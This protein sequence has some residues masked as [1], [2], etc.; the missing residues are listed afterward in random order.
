MSS[1]IHLR[2][3]SAYSLLEGAIKIPDLI[4]KCIHLR[5]P[6]VALT[7]TAN[8]FGAM[9]FSLTAVKSGVQPII[10]CQ[11]NFC[12]DLKEQHFAKIVLLA[13][14]HQGYLNLLELVSQ[15]YL[16]PNQ[17]VL[18]CVTV[19][20]LAG[21]TDGLICLT[22][23]YDGPLNTI[24]EKDEPHAAV[25]IDQ[26]QKLF[27]DHLY[28]ELQRHFDSRVKKYE[29]DIVQRELKHENAHIDLAY[30]KGIPLVA[31]NDAYFLEKEKHEAH[32]ILLAI[33]EGKNEY[34]D[35][36]RQL[37]EEHY[38][39]SSLEMK[40]LFYDLPEAFDNTFV[41]S[42]RCSHI[43]KPVNPI[44]PSFSQFTG[45]EDEEE[46]RIQAKAGLADRLAKISYVENEQEYWDR[47]EEELGI[48][49]AMGFPGYFLIVADFIKWATS[50]NI[51]VGPGRGS[52]AGSVVAWALTITGLDP[53][54]F[55]LL[56]ERF[57]NPERVS[58]PD[59]D[60][61][62]CQER[63]D[64]VIHYVQQKYGKE[65]V[66]QIITFGKMQARIVLRDVGRALGLPYGQIDKIAKLVPNNPASPVSLGEAIE[67]EPRLKEE[68]QGDPHIKRLV[69]IAT[70]LEGLYRHASTHAAGVVIGD[71]DLTQLVALYKD[72][73]SDMPAT[74]FNMKFV[75]LTGLVKFDFLGLKT[76][77]VIQKA[78]DLVRINHDIDINLET[79]PL[80]DTKTFEMLCRGE[81]MGVFQIEG[82]GM[83]ETIKKMKPTRFEEL[84]ALISLYRPGPMENIP[85]F[86]ARKFGEEEIE[87]LHPL[88]GEI[89]SETYGIMIY[90]EQVMQAAQRLAG[91]S[92]GKADLLRR[93]MGKKVKEEMD[94]QRRIFLD[95]ATENKIDQKTANE[96][97]DQMAKFAGYGFNKSH[98]AG[99]ALM[100]YQTAYLKA[101]YPV[102]FFTSLMSYDLINTDKLNVYRQDA[103]SFGL[104]VL[105][106]DINKSNAHFK[107][108][109]YD[110]EW[111]IRYALGALKNVG[112][113]FLV[114]LE[115]IRK[116]KGKFEDIYDFVKKVGKK[117][118]NKK[119][120][121][122]MIAAGA[123]DSICENRAQL[124]AAIELLADFAATMEKEK[125]KG[126]KSLFGDMDDSVKPPVLPK[127]R[128]WGAVERLNKEF[129]SVGYYLFDHPIDGYQQQLAELD[130][131]R[132]HEIDEAE[133]GSLTIACVV[134][135]KSEKITR[136]G[137]RMAFVKLSDS[138]GAIEVTVF[139]DI[140][141][142]AGEQLASNDPLLVTIN[143]RLDGDLQRL[144][145]TR[146][147]SLEA[148]VAHVQQSYTFML[149]SK[150]DII[151]LK[152]RIQPSH[153]A[154]AL[155]V[156][157]MLSLDNHLVSVEIPHKFNFNEKELSQL[158][159]KIH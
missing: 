19:A 86:I 124:F 21:K 75:E 118:L 138:W 17:Q 147:E 133:P 66:A 70:Q 63:R 24:F 140:L 128:D 117:N 101:N 16:S 35:Q 76:L 125:K 139:S 29:H 98:A 114:E 6:S 9:E 26:F 158:H 2:T 80:D 90:Q 72:P 99:Y 7:D 156:K 52:G 55:N 127:I 130:V 68:M 69:K 153:A 105:P 108:E 152:E 56:F 42:Q 85:A 34:D 120:M 74:Q 95:G 132:S 150:D 119:S 136:K 149:H 131:C 89:L 145:V 40:E 64:E 143:K 157:L 71:R 129:I 103:K 61:D 79:L 46:L 30:D 141:V 44:L 53:I 77:S 22:G 154:D 43:L 3:H 97:F 110:G 116:N 12:F 122:N 65:K 57:L 134:V 123:F 45:R 100:L 155:K 87:Y 113:K 4:T 58:L 151:F 38:F 126:L 15:T 54:R 23:G 62:F 144:T 18:P 33:A 60:I 59:F 39:K 31:T 146:I 109:Q 135:G 121:E 13:K 106:P 83:R 20:D 49:C 159:L 51:P 142:E 148:M 96:I 27:P 107:M 28:I 111:S 1:F 73:K 112:D 93:A 32:D 48:I 102:A 10:G 11:V 50:Q 5:M 91:Y 14:N 94:A 84:I 82:A 67:I 37:T 81:T 41:I 104:K 88:L 36:R 25:L 115:K 137:D 92:L 78:V 8:L 47:L